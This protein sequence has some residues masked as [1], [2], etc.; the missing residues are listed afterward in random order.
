MMS[1]G[2]QQFSALSSRM[3]ESKAASEGGLSKGVGTLEVVCVWFYRGRWVT[4]MGTG[5]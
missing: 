4:S 1:D 5:S 2:N 3:I